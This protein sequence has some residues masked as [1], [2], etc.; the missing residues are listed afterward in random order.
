MALTP[1]GAVDEWQALAAKCGAH[2]MLALVADRHLHLRGLADEA[3]EWP[4]GRAAE[5]AEQRA[6]ADAAHFL[7]IGNRQMDRHR[8]LRLTHFRDHGETDR[9]KTLHG[10]CRGR[11]AGR[12]AR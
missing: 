2:P 10:S 9:D 6:D 1:L 8:Q 12:R 5:L 3:A 4:D 7:V 11:R